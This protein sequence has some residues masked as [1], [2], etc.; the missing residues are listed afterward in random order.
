[1]DQTGSDPG[2]SELI[3]NSRNTDQS[4]NS[5]I[6]PDLIPDQ[7]PALIQAVKA[8]ILEQNGL[9]EK[10]ARATYTIGQQEE[11]IHN[12]EAQLEA[13]RE[14][15]KTLPSP[16]QMIQLEQE[17]LTLKKQATEKKI[18]FWAK[19]KTLFQ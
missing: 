11:R 18:S 10:Y 12:L 5:Q 2:R 1:M 3:P 4:T 6:R 9:S 15:I 8:A 14:Q 7:S 17:V 19:L 13:A 16:Q